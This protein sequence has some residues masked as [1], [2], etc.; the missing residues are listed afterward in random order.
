MIK[1]N[2]PIRILLLGY[3]YI[4]QK[5]IIRAIEN[6][7]NFILVGIASKSRYKGIPKEY[8]IYKSYE[9]A[10]KKSNCDVVYI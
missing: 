2:P 4:A 5:S 7:S 8:I 9:E 6:N 1:K 3:S 10:I